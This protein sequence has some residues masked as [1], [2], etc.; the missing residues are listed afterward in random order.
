MHTVVITGRGEVEL[1]YMWLPTC[2]GMN[3]VLKA[4]MEKALADKVVGI[5]LDEQGLEKVDEIVIEY[6][7]SKFPGVKGLANYL[8]ALKFIEL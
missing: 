7:E 4:E 5:P 1:N 3:S 8:D 6:L 2:I